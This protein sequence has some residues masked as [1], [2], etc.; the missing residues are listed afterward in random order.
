MGETLSQTERYPLDYERRFGGVARLYT[1]EGAARLAQA[2][3]TVVGLGGVGSW[4]AEALARTAVGKL[5]LIDLDNIAESNTN[6]QLQAL[7]GAYGK[8]KAQALKE[9]I[10]L[11]NPLCEVTMVEDFVDEENVSEMLHTPV[12]LDCTD[13]VKAKAAMAAFVQ[14]SGGLFITCGAAGGKTSAL[15]ILV[16]DLAKAKGDPLL[17][18][19]RYRLRKQYGYP[20]PKEGKRIEKFGITAVYTADPVVRPEGS[21]DITGGLACSGYGSGVVVT[22]AIG[23]T[24]ASVAINRIAG[25]QK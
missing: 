19:L 1:K 18:N 6:R 4:A 9:R 17:S 20:R 2:S 7:T 10:A 15:N 25:I 11:I 12:V 24:A 21:C 23:F 3:V 5:T 22:A 14:K 16:D 8:P 13:Q